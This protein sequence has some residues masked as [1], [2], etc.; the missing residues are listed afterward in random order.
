MTTDDGEA[1]FTLSALTY[2]RSILNDDTYTNAEKYAIT[3]IYEY[4]EAAKAYG[5][6]TGQI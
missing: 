5:A 2:I 3:A 1:E 6:A 4:A